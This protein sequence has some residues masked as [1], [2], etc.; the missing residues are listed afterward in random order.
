MPL[1]KPAAAR[2]CGSTS[3]RARTAAAADKRSAFESERRM[4]P[5]YS[6]P[7]RLAPRRAAPALVLVVEAGVAQRRSA[8]LVGIIPAE[9][10][11]IGGE[12][13]FQ[14]ADAMDGARM[15]RDELGRICKIRVLEGLHQPDHTVGVQSG[16]R[17][18]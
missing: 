15:V 5:R 16:L 18:G 3:V 12:L 9:E 8:T 13:V 7:G 4:V 6:L 17:A 11:R 2:T 10:G 1:L 14:R